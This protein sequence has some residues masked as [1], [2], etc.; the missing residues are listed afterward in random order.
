MFIDTLRDGHPT[1]TT[2]Y[3]PMVW[4]PTNKSWRYL[5]GWPGSGSSGITVGTTTITSGTD[6]RVPFNDAG[7]YNEDAGFTYNKTTDRLTLS[8]ATAPGLTVETSSASEQELLTLKNTNT[9]FVPVTF[10]FQSD[11][12][13]LGNTL[14]RT[15]WLTSE[16]E[17]SGGRL[18]IRT[19]DGT[20]SGA[21]RWFFTTAGVFETPAGIQIDGQV[22]RLPDVGGASRIDF[23]ASNTALGY[24]TV[25]GNFFSTSVAGD[26]A[27]KNT[28]G[29]L[30]LGLT[31][32][33]M[34]VSST[35]VL[36]TQP[37]QHEGHLTIKD[38]SLA[39]TP[40]SG[41]VVLGANNDA[42]YEK[43]DGSVV[44]KLYEL[45]SKSK[46][47]ESVSS[48]ENTFFF[49]TDKAITV[50]KVAYALTGSS[51]SVTFDIHFHTD[52]SSGSPSELFGTNVVGTSTTGTTTTSF[53][54][55]TIPAGSYVWIVT[56]AVSGTITEIGITLTFK[57]D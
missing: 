38:N 43:T 39:S 57:E 47:L 55:A 32:E 49:Y 51:P 15:S 9:S 4:S 46:V 29:D 44:N 50:Q 18:N 22:I 24:V 36:F 45:Q 28:T 30:L 13:S 5:T 16:N 31:N 23:G 3:K 12:S 42:L 17:G 6:T 40:S 37:T 11:Y 27:I 20:A 8:G 1:D 33:V 34:R 10:A 25:P 41:N 21:N 54:D 48:S 26:I 53:N 2:T 7:I 19:S 52:R 35:R 56:S 14:N